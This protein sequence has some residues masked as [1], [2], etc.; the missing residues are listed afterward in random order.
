VNG[1]E[2]YSLGR[3]LTAIAADAL[4]AGSF[5]RRVTP[6]ARLVLEDAAAHP[7]ASV[8]EIAERAGLLASQVSAL[9]GQLAADG[10]VEASPGPAGDRV[11]VSRALLFGGHS[12]VP[13]DAAL[14]VALGTADP[15][16]V[17]EVAR[18]LESLA[19]RLGTGRGLGAPAGFDP[20]FFDAAY[21]D[22]PP[23][24]IGHPQPALAELADAGAFRGR[25][26]DV[27]C[28]TGEHALLAAGRGLRATGI[29]ASPAAIEIARRKAAERNL[30]AEF[31]VRDALELTALAGQFETVIDSALFHVFADDDLP[32]Y[33]AGLR[34]VV[35]AGG[36]YLMLCFSDRQPPGFGPRRVRQQEI[37]AV[38]GDGWRIDEIEPATLEVTVDPAGVRAW[39]AVITRV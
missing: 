36:R 6:V 28:G 3:A 26:L 24:E 10:L 29:D 5:P 4:P 33:E 22:T 34:Q 32:R 35:P 2:L 14:A 25:V 13:V 37:R 21:R 39:R 12:A 31:S 23:W 17:R 38:F 11:S 19:R 18:A 16:E 8:G 20:G 30:A 27:G 1:A 15:G 7:G 9:V